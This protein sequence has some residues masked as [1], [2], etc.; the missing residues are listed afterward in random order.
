M[1]FEDL[2][3]IENF[4]LNPEIEKI[5]EPMLSEKLKLEKKKLVNGV[6]RTRNC[7]DFEDDLFIIPDFNLSEYGQLEPI[8]EFLHE[9]E[10]FILSDFKFDYNDYVVKE[11]FHKSSLMH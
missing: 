4:E 8:E 5:I 2:V 11:L 9:D 3:L 6:K 1:F 10:D 7:I